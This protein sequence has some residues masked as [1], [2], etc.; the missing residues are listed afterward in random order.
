MN[1]SELLEII[2][3][4]DWRENCAAVKFYGPVSLFLRGGIKVTDGYTFKK[5]FVTSDD[6]ACYCITEGAHSGRYLPQGEVM[7]IEIKPKEK[8]DYGAQWANI[9]RHMME[10]K[11]NPDIAEAIEKHLRGEAEHISGMQNYWKRTDR[12]KIMS[13]TDLVGEWTIPRMMEAA[14]ARDAH[15]DDKKEGWKD[16]RVNRDGI[17]RD[18]SITLWFTNADNVR[19]SGA[20]EY[21]GCGNGD[22]YIMFNRNTAFYSES[23]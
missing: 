5:L 3:K 1:N 21:R 12:P 16:F 15:L 4:T 19:Y 6:R 2:K 18:R 7:D 17:K 8:K 14:H 20:S 22:Y 23:D 10:N 11:I 9:A 13:F